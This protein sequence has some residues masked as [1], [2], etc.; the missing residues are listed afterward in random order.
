[1]LTFQKPLVIA[2]VIFFV[3][4]LACYSQEQK[5][6]DNATV[7]NLNEDSLK[8]EQVRT[9]TAVD[10]LEFAQQE[11]WRRQGDHNDPDL[12][13]KQET[14]AA[15]C[16]SIR[17][18]LLSDPNNSSARLQLG[19]LLMTLGEEK[20]ARR[21]F[22][23]I[24]ADSQ[25][26]FAAQ[27]KV[28]EIDSSLYAS[29]NEGFLHPDSDSARAAYEVYTAG[30][31]AQLNGNYA[32]AI[33]KYSQA[34]TLMPFVSVYYQALATAYDNNGELD[35]AIK[36]YQKAIDTVGSLSSWKNWLKSARQRK[37]F[38]LV[39]EAFAKQ[40]GTT[41]TQRP[42]SGLEQQSGAATSGTGFVKQTAASPAAEQRTTPENQESAESSK[43]DLAG[44][45]KTYEEALSVYD[46]AET[47]FNLG[48]AYQL[49]TPPDL[50]KALEHYMKAIDLDPKLTE[51]HYW[52]G[53]IDELINQP[54]A[55]LPEYLQY[56]KSQPHGSYVT[57]CKERIR[58]LTNNTSKS[59]SAENTASNQE[60]KADLKK[61]KARI[62]KLNVSAT[63]MDDPHKS[64]AKRIASDQKTERLVKEIDNL[65]AKQ[66]TL[67]L[68]DEDRNEIA[69]DM[70]LMN[71]SAVEW[72]QEKSA[73][74]A[75]YQA[76]VQKIEH[77]TPR[78]TKHVDELDTTSTSQATEHKEKLPELHVYSYTEK[79][80]KT[81]HPLSEQDF[82]YGERQLQMMLRDRPAMAKCV[83]PG[84]PIWI[85][86][87]RQFAGEFTGS[88]Y[89][90]NPDPDE[91]PVG[92][93]AA[94]HLGPHNGKNGWVWVAPGS[95][96]AEDGERQWAEAVFEL[97]NIRNIPGFEICE[98][99]KAA[100][101]I[102]SNEFSTQCSS[103]EYGALRNRASF[104][105][106]AWLPHA[107][108]LAME[109]HGDYWQADVPTTYKRWIHKFPKNSW[110]LKYYQ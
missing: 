85:W 7:L 94:L 27:D 107:E 61:L 31:N 67:E 71:R 82:K 101:K 100:G 95:G 55:A 60:L 59:P 46:D 5:S 36:Y 51:A 68:A 65:L 91:P 22:S 44:A 102:N 54:E 103:L 70:D 3:F 50:A 19:N 72:Y 39:K 73:R 92:Q 24:P 42:S 86:C 28:S 57:H 10:L 99:E 90:W 109:S 76:L 41:T 16:A 17:H 37:S 11:S 8:A 23:L 93:P 38:E 80:P 84:D 74:F 56:L 34:T 97:F 62:A 35:N 64:D 48:T 79:D 53:R 43:P 88:R 81:I 30:Y 4:C 14:F 45:I 83:A 9:N 21:Q 13:S 47:H 32:E 20:E 110:Y 2:T 87:A 66:E 105:N 26:Y 29:F 63:R 15:T 58:L 98:Q 69:A 40:T 6:T 104:Y 106:E 75:K 18:S 96:Q 77:E 78:L 52:M 108:A 1:M 33:H 12:L 49:L 25:D 89:Y